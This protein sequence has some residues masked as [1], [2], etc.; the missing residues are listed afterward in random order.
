[1]ADRTRPMRY[2][3]AEALRAILDTDEDS[4]VEISDVSEE[5]EDHIS[6]QSEHSDTQSTDSNEDENLQPN[7]PVRGRGRAQGHGCGLIRAQ[8]WRRRP[9]IHNAPNRGMSTKQNV[10]T[11]RNGT[12]WQKNAPNI[13]RRRDQDIIRQQPGITNEVM[14]TSP[15]EAFNYFI[16]PAMIDL[17][18]LETNREAR[19]QITQYNIVNVE[20][21]KVWTP[22]DATEVKAFIGLCLLAGAHRSHHEPVRSLWSESEG[23]PIYTATMSRSRFTSI[24]KYLRFDNRATRAER[25]A[26]DKLAAF[27][28]FWS[29]FQA[30]LPKFYVPG[31]DL[32][33]DEQLVSF[34]GRCGFRQYIPSKPAK[35]GIKIWWCCDAATSYP[36]TGQVYLGRQPGEERDIG[37][38]QRIVKDLVAPWMRSGRN[39]TADNFFSS[40]SLA[41]DLLQEGLTY[42]G[43]VRSNKADVPDEMRARRDRDA[44]SSLFGFKDQ[45]TL[46]SYVPKKNKAVLALST[47]HHD[48]SVEGDDCKPQ[49]ILHYNATKSGVDNLDHLVSA[50][51]CR[52]KVN[53]WPVVLFG[54]CVDVSALAAFVVWI[55]KFPDWKATEGTRRRRYFLSELG[56]QLVMPH[57]ES[58]AQIPTL[59]APIRMAMRM[60]GIEPVACQQAHRGPQGN[61]RKRCTLCPH[62][63]DKKVRLICY[64]CKKPVCPIHSVQQTI[65]EQCL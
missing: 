23:Q 9:G 24:L 17:I 39:V 65:C 16:T 36:L 28:D 10:F 35:Y 29:M 34:R 26:V 40:V 31:T 59:H 32:C 11:G 37:Q 33:V 62:S 41:E 27:R 45:V 25:Q 7:E 4:D 61:K 48:S 64:N 53:R 55:A 13:G 15:V 18:V 63:A 1:M 50:F 19:R 20:H 56:N 47:M 43:T 8:G 57:L 22:V 46:V 12:V 6:E 3:A 5:E 42:V 38:G 54:N 44:H 52:R 49:I 14:C 30:Q 51:T 60:I 2:T 58:R 21:Q